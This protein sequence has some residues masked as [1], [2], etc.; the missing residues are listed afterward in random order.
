MTIQFA[1]RSCG[2]VLKTSDDKAG[3]K[4]RCPGCSE[5]I[6]VPSSGA[7]VP[8]PPQPPRPPRA[9][10]PPSVRRRRPQVD[11]YADDQDEFDDD[12]FESPV[13][14]GRSRARRTSRGVSKSC[15]M[16]GEDVDRSDRNCP[17]CGE[18]L[19]GSGADLS[20]RG[21]SVPLEVVDVMPASWSIFRQNL[22]VCSGALAI[23]MLAYFAAWLV[24][25]FVFPAAFLL[26]SQ[27]GIGIVLGLGLLIAVGLGGF[28]FVIALQLGLQRVYIDIVTGENT[29]MAGL[30]SCWSFVPR[31]LLISVVISLLMIPVGLV[32]GLVGMVLG[33]IPILGVLTLIFVYVLAY[34]AMISIWPL[35]YVLVDFDPP[36]IGAL[37][38]S[39]D[40]TRGNRLRSFWLFL[41]IGAVLTLAFVGGGILVA[42][43]S[44]AVGQADPVTGMAVG[45]LLGL[46]LLILGFVLAG[47]G[48]TAVAVMYC[49]LAGHPTVESD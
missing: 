21:E 37:T 14:S 18:A 6:E 49:R 48:M 34:A 27:D 38:E 35:G 19:R 13:S 29:G 9:P 43:V 23:A 11:E 5:I 24:G 4:A 26:I 45:T 7:T 20:E 44:A 41:M 10:A 28:L 8:E 1:C 3:K 12:E 32:I 36:G 46:F 39:F 17:S 25:F 2:Q 47:Y 30:F 31:L 16:C 22:G 40:L 42:A 15:P 33:S